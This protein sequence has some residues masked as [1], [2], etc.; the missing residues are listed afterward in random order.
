MGGNNQKPVRDPVTG[1]LTYY[2]STEGAITFENKP[3]S[4][5]PTLSP[6]GGAL[7]RYGST[8]RG[9]GGLGRGGNSGASA[10]TLDAGK[11]RREEEAAK[12]QS[13][14]GSTGKENQH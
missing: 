14:E 7:D 10:D 13:E 11:D 6:K 1:K 2:R 4:V 9:R 12:W 5:V 3:A 8:S